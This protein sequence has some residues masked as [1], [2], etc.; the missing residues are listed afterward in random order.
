MRVCPPPPGPYPGADLVQAGGDGFGWRV[1]AENM[2]FQDPGVFVS[3]HV[4]K[5]PARGGD[6]RVNQAIQSRCKK[7]KRKIKDAREGM[8]RLTALDER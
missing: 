7:K 4:R 3:R 5:I 2:T 1:T 8:M 6:K